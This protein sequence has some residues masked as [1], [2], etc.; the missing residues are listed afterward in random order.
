MALDAGYD[1]SQAAEGRARLRYGARSGA[2]I[3]SAFTSAGR[4]LRQWLHCTSLIGDAWHERGG[5][6]PRRDH[7]GTD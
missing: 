2:G 5:H 6:R 1:G 4:R 7:T 3:T